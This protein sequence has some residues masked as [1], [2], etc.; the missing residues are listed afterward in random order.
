MVSTIEKAG[1]LFEAVRLLLSKDGILTDGRNG[2]LWVEAFGKYTWWVDYPTYEI[3]IGSNRGIA[4]YDLC[5]PQ[6]FEHVKK[7]L[8]G[9]PK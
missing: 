9:G 6:V 7:F 4:A 3:R 1:Q 5:D 2:I 8:R